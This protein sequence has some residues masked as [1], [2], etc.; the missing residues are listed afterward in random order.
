[1]V[2]EWRFDDTADRELRLSWRESDGP[3]VVA[4]ASRGFGSQLIERNLN[5]TLGGTARL[6]FAP[7]GLRAEIAARLR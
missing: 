1:V 7:E 4:P 2:V 3:M 6:D 5:Q